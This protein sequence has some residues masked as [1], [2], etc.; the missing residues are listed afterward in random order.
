MSGYR[1]TTL[2]HKPQVQHKLIRFA[3]CKCVR[4]RSLKKVVSIYHY[5]KQQVVL[6]LIQFVMEVG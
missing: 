5:V 6:L 3:G 2:A 1:S 4:R